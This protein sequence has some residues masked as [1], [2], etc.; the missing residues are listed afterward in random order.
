MR[1]KNNRRGVEKCTV[2]KTEVKSAQSASVNMSCEPEESEPTYQD[3]IDCIK[4]ISKKTD[5][6]RAQIREVT[7]C[8]STSN[9]GVAKG[10]PD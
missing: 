6:L 10:N 9:S 3:V 1:R 2:K 7:M 4:K 5:D 8:A